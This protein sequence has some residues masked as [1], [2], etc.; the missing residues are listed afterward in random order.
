DV[1]RTGQLQAVGD[2]GGAYTCVGDRKTLQHDEPRRLGIPDVISI[3]DVDA[4][5]GGVTD[6]EILDDEVARP[7]EVQP[8]AASL[9]DRARFARRTGDPDGRG[10]GSSSVR[11]KHSAWIRPGVEID[12]RSR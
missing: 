10:T 7:D 2:A 8:V 12:G 5:A 4:V 6:V 9:D 11:E 1:A 3:V